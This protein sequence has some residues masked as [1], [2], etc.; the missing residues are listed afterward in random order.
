MQP[1]DGSAARDVVPSEPPTPTSAPV[2][3]RPTFPSLPPR[4]ADLAG[5]SALIAGHTASLTPYQQMQSYLAELANPTA[6]RGYDVSLDIGAN[7][8][9]IQQAAPGEPIEVT[10]TRPASGSAATADAPVVI[11]LTY[12][13]DGRFQSSQGHTPHPAPRRGAERFFHD[14]LTGRLSDHASRIFQGGQLFT[15]IDSALQALEGRFVPESQS[16]WHDHLVAHNGRVYSFRRMNF[17]GMT[18]IQ[19]PQHNQIAIFQET[20]AEQVRV[21]TISANGE[22]EYAPGRGGREPANQRLIDLLNQIVPPL[23][24]AKIDPAAYQARLRQ[25]LQSLP[26]FRGIEPTIRRSVDI[27]RDFSMGNT[28][29]GHVQDFFRGWQLFRHLRSPRNWTNPLNAAETATLRPPWRLSRAM[30]GEMLHWARQTAT[31]FLFGSFRN[32][33]PANDYIRLQLFPEGGGQLSTYRNQE[34]HNIVTAGPDGPA[35]YADQEIR[36]MQREGIT[37][38]G[39]FEALQAAVARRAQGSGS[40]FVLRVQAAPNFDLNRLHFAPGGETIPIRSVSEA[41]AQLQRQIPQGVEARVDT[42]FDQSLVGS[43]LAT[44]GEPNRIVVD[45]H[46]S[47]PVV[48]LDLRQQKIQ[49]GDSEVP[50]VEILIRHGENTYARV[51]E[52]GVFREDLARDVHQTSMRQAQ[53]GTMRRSFWARAGQGGLRAF[54]HVRASGF[55][56]G[57]SHFASLPLVWGAE[58]LMLSPTERRLIGTPGLEANLHPGYIWSHV[59]KPFGAIAVGSGLGTVAVDGMYNLRGGLWRTLASYRG[60]EAT[61]SQA[62]RGARPSFYNA[63]PFSRP[64]SPS[65][66][67][68]GFLQ[69]AVPLFGGLLFADRLQNGEWF[70]PNFRRQAVNVGAVSFGS[71]LLLRGIQASSGLSGAMVRRGLFA[72][73]A[74]AAGARFGLTFRGGLALAVLEMTVLGIVDARQRREQLQLT[75]RG[76]RSDLGQAIDRRNELITRLEMGEEIEPRHLFSADAHVQ[77]AQAAYRRF[78]E[79]TE[80]TEGSGNPR[81]LGLA[82]DFAAEEQRYQ[83]LR[84]TMAEDPV[85]LT[86]LESEHHRRLTELRGRYQHMEAELDQLYARYGAARTTGGEGSNES[87]RD[88]LARQAQALRD[89]PDLAN[90]AADAS[91]PAAAIQPPVSVESDDGRLIV[92]QLRWKAAQEPGFILWSRERR[93]DYIL[94]EFRGYTVE[95]ADGRHRPWN[96][97]EALAFLD[98]V[99]AANIRRI[100]NLEAPLTL[101]ADG[102]GLRTANLQELLNSEQAIRARESSSHRHVSAHT[103]ALADNVQDLDRQMTEYYRLSNER[104]AIALSNFLP[105][106][107]VAMAHP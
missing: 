97:S 16:I 78:L 61:L 64:V 48:Q 43:L 94:R 101:P 89:N 47:Q 52:N 21:A 54:S 86:N 56:Y 76:L 28:P 84:A 36:Q 35:W 65:L 67:F 104:S 68:R 13:S 12:L 23:E 57:A 33:R 26:N 72:E 92:D 25:T 71:A 81:E 34:L 10:V 4:S 7:R 22:V 49:M 99:D 44:S 102:H 24:D 80:R 83:N 11:R 58:R 79:L 42:R 19:N 6:S 41:W 75:G 96:Q 106:E 91:A 5:L 87:L 63:S 74:T 59:A 1:A 100:H 45:F 107:T 50:R 55:T 17:L 73:T 88:F 20:G 27:P 14:T 105:S 40:P 29:R 9:Q 18:D 53:E 31:W 38:A 77:E 69:R 2:S 70:S 32:P 90:Q 98:A 30:G 37:F 8:Y 60:T 103:E 51:F 15:K 46:Q 85:A 82:N 39:R 3:A 95:G 66:L 93:A 62:W